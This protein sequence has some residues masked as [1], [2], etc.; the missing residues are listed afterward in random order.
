MA[1]SSAYVDGPGDP[2]RSGTAHVRT[3][4]D[5]S[6]RPLRRLAP[7]LAA[8]A[9]GARGTGFAGPRRADSARPPLQRTI[10]LGSPSGAAGPGG[11][12][13]GQSFEAS[14]AVGRDSSATRG[15]D[16]AGAGVGSGS[17]SSLLGRNLPSPSFRTEVRLVSACAAVPI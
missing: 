6:P 8:L 13:V 10:L 1:S 2:I 16:A 15:N 12:L 3:A 11:R 9:H 14:F 17:E 5:L 4:G 7:R